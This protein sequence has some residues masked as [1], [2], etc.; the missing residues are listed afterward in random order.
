MKHTEKWHNE[1]RVG[2]VIDSKDGRP[3]NTIY[4]IEGNS[5]YFRDENGQTYHGFSRVTLRNLIKGGAWTQ[6]RQEVES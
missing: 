5:L 6:T 4:K 1:F 2:D 3:K